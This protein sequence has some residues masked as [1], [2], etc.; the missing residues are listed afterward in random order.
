MRG[1]LR[2]GPRL[3]VGCGILQEQCH[4]NRTTDALSM[5]V[6][7]TASLVSHALSGL[8]HAAGSVVDAL[9]SAKSDA[10]KKAGSGEKT[11]DA[12]QLANLFAAY[13]AAAAPGNI[14]A[15][16]VAGVAVTRSAGA[17]P[18]AGTNVS[19]VAGTNPHVGAVA[20]RVAGSNPTPGVAVSRITNTALLA[21]RV[22]NAPLHGSQVTGAVPLAARGANATPLPLAT[23]S[24]PPTNNT[25]KVSLKFD[26][27]NLAPLL[28]LSVMLAVGPT[29]ALT[30][31]AT[32][33]AL[34][35]QPTSPVAKGVTPA[36][37][38]PAIAPANAT[39]TKAATV[40]ASAKLNLPTAKETAPASAHPSAAKTVP[41][42]ANTP[43]LVVRKSTT[44]AVEMPSTATVRQGQN[45]QPAALPVPTVALNTPATPHEQM[46]T[47]ASALT[48]HDVPIPVAR[49]NSEGAA[50]PPASPSPQTESART[51][52]PAVAE[53]K[54]SPSLD[55]APVA[56][57]S[58][59]I[60]VTLAMISALTSRNTE[61]TASRDGGLPVASRDDPPP[62]TITP[63]S[64]TGQ[65]GIPVLVTQPVGS[66]QVPTPLEPSG[67]PSNTPVAEQ[68]TRSF[69]AKADFVNR[70]GRTDFHLHLE[71]PQLGSVQIHLTATNH[72][73]SARV[74]VTQDGA[75]Q[76]LEGQAQNLR[77]SLA[78][79][80]LVLSKFDVTQQGG[81]FSG[82]GRRPPPEV[83]LPTP[84]ARFASSTVAV[85]ARTTPLVSVGGIDIL[86]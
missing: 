31:A 76:L 72:T 84:P 38:V 10:V 23:A 59:R 13:L 18:H 63:L 67:T 26:N 40:P 57:G 55:V 9:H 20:S 68:L 24:T 46:T 75:R 77:Q 41:A 51:Q 7:T 22:T 44:A 73:I 64:V 83:P 8:V 61:P 56:E 4:T 42:A 15:I 81:G 37:V 3:W 69:V 50:V 27:T 85:I 86:A 47:E 65:V 48:L 28:P 11:K 66:N 39:S 80:G 82:S 2:G 43:I 58:R 53:G 16:P 49:T 74:I 52:G 60:P 17:S 62:Q 78:D 12:S 14:N 32:V 5:P 79:A 29:T 33:N 71:P 25:Q 6:F 34:A 54:S 36:T 45:P 35:A 70:D 1:R 30:A 19:R 21:L